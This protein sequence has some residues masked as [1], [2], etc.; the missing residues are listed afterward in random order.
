[1]RWLPATLLVLVFAA[2]C[3]SSDNSSQ[4]L[5]L[6]PANVTP[7]PAA[8]TTPFPTP[9]IIQP[10]A[11]LSPSAPLYIALGDSLSAGIGASDSSQTAFVPLVHKALGEGVGLLNLGHSGDTSEQLLSHGHLDEAI[12][13]IVRQNGDDD[14]DNDVKLATLEIGGNDLLNLYS[15]LVLTG[16]CPTVK[17]SLAKPNCVDALRG[18]L[19]RFKP[20]LKTALD[21][22]LAADPKLN[23]ILMTLYNPF[24]GGIPTFDE[25]G[26]L[27]LE[28]LPDTPFPEGVNDIIRAQARDSGV[29]LVDWYPLFEGKALQYISG[30]FIHPNDAGYRVLA[31]AVIQALGAAR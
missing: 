2:A 11:T 16:Q 17:D 5:S 14:P 23:I 29:T 25:L 31:D 7:T 18:A 21:R 30:D 28:G 6:S 22:L 20:N 4:G 12:A 27:G 13:N 19:D 1:M 3:G 26:K 24:S 8:S 9:G 15:S 10:T